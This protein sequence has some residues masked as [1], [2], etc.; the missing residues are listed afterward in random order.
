MDKK[1]EIVEISNESPEFDEGFAL[2]VI[3]LRLE[4]TTE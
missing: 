4:V 3:A 2:H 1:F